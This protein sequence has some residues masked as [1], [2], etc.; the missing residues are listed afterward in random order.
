M[1]IRSIIRQ[2]LKLEPD[3]PKFKNFKIGT[4]SYHSKINTFFEPEI[5]IGNYTSIASNLS[6]HGQS[7]HK[8][9]KNKK[10]VSTYPFGKNGDR[11]EAQAT[12]KGK[13][14]IGHD[15]WI[16]RDVTI[17]S[18]VTIGNGTIIGANS[19]VAKNI[20]A[21]A[22]VVG[23]PAKVIKYRYNKTIITKLL[24][25]KWWNWP[26]SKIVKNLKYFKDVNEFVKRFS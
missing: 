13:I 23:N 25:I 17:L 21:F 1:A 22:I 6:L 19:V 15:V 8:F 4:G 16:G 12:S 18:G 3:K 24:K 5:E 26:K 20:L 14:K 9:I 7:E 10:L 2:F 11:D